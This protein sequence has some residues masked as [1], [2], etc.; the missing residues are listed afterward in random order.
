MMKKRVSIFTAAVLCFV[1]SY[2]VI[3]PV[4][5][6]VDQ[7]YDQLR[8]LVD[9]MGLIRESYVE[10]KENKE[11]L[12][13]AINGMVRSLDPFSQFM[14]PD[15]YKEMKT[16]TEG[17]FGGLGIRISIKSDWLTIITPIPGTPAYRIGLLPEDRIVKIE[18]TSTAGIS[19]NDAVKKLRGTPGTKVTIS[20]AREGEKEPIDY[21]ITREIIKI[22]TI[23]AKM[24]SDGVGYIK[25][26]EFNANTERDLSKALSSLKK[27]KME[28]LV[29]DLR[30][31][32]GGLLDIAVD[33]CKEFIGDGKLI[34]YTQGRRPESRRNYTSSGP[35]PHK[36]LP[37][38]V[39]VNRGSASGSEIV[40]GALQDLKRALIVGTTTFGKGS[41]QSVFPFP[42]GNALRLT[43]AKY[44]TPS[45]RSIHRDEKTGA[46]GIIPDV[47]VEVPREVEAKLYMQSEEVFALGKKP[48]SS[49]EKKD[50]IE[51]AALQRAIELLKMREILMSLKDSK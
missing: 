33:V 19:I 24:L 6:A 46:G 39:L 36:D 51:D 35:A 8:L 22:E 14:E 9:V 47:V 13:G 32:P 27:Q 25:L 50:V 11:L 44:Y 49:V 29:L 1:I 34:V 28:S 21:T 20:V 4:R 43:T 2:S 12:L 15:T 17:Q 7:T 26:T 18:G 30:N 38:V 3:T 10:P 42:D 5:A 23:K 31:N 37:M 45:G 40:A 16:E 41:V 48:K